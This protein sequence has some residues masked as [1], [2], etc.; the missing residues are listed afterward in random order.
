MLAKYRSQPEKMNKNIFRINP[1]DLSLMFTRDNL[2]KP[3]NTGES[4]ISLQILKDCG[5]IRGLASLLDSNI[6]TGIVGDKADIVRRRHYFGR[7]SMPM[8]KM[9]SLWWTKLPRQY[10]DHTTQFLL[11]AATAY[12]AIS[13]FTNRVQQ[14]YFETLTIYFGVLFAN[15]IQAVSEYS[16]D[17]QWLSLRREMNN[18]KLVVLRGNG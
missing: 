16:K 15:L 13:S 5:Y 12:L 9:E 2:R 8:P 1:E 3:S 11:I 4:R 14:G 10:E 18:Q 17:T 6:D 7:H